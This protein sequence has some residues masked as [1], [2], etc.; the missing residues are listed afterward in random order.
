MSH[1]Q[2]LEKLWTEILEVAK[3]KKY[4]VQFLNDVYEIN[5]EKFSVLSY[6]CNALAPEEISILI[7]S[8]LLKKLKNQIP[9]PTNQY[10]SF[11]EIPDGKFLYQ[12]F[13]ERAIAPLLRKYGTTPEFIFEAAKRLN[14]EKSNL[15]EYAVEIKI[16]DDVKIIFILYPGDDELPTE[17]VFLFDKN[18]RNIFTVEEIEVLCIEIA[19]FL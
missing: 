9:V 13:K 18:I 6:S 15:S 3:D 2:A 1:K 12:R 19:K 5:L 17:G 16:F 4:E 7:L 11:N 14:G 8:Y 10:I